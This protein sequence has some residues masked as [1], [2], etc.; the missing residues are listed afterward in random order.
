MT[1]SV[2]SRTSFSGG[3]PARGERMRDVG[4]EAAGLEVAHRD[5]DAHLQ[6]PALGAGRPVGRGRGPSTHRCSG[7][8]RPSSSAREM[9]SSGGTVPEHAGGPSGRAP[10]G[11]ARGARPA[12][13]IGWYTTGTGPA[14]APRAGRGPAA[15]GGPWRCRWRAPRS[16]RSSCRRPWRRA[17]RGRR[18]D[19][20]GGVLGRLELRQAD[21]AGDVEDRTRRARR[22]GWARGRYGPQ[23]VDEPLGERRG[24]L[25]GAGHQ[26]GELVAAEPGD[27]VPVA[28]AA[29]QQVGDLAEQLV[30]G[31]VPGDVVDRLEAVEVDQQHAAGLAL[32]GAAR[33]ASSAAMRRARLGSPVR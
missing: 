3:R 31:L 15:C 8:I 23:V 20:G 21:A 14:R 17:G 2:I 24:L 28:G 29:A 13:T 4:A 9:N 12:P 32:G 18:P 10:P 11:R 1:D 19:R 22:R 5:V 30:A 25:G 33:A 7:T 16:G 26:D 27:Q 6:V